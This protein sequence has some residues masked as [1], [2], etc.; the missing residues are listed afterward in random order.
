MLNKL[1]PHKVHPF[2]NINGKKGRRFHRP[3]P[4]ADVSKTPLKRIRPTQFVFLQVSGGVAVI[5]SLF[6]AELWRN[7]R[8]NEYE[9]RVKEKAILFWQVIFPAN[10]FRPFE[11]L[12]VLFSGMS[13]VF[14]EKWIYSFMNKEK[15]NLKKSCFRVNFLNKLRLGVPIENRFICCLNDFISPFC[16]SC[17]LLLISLN[18]FVPVLSESGEQMGNMAAAERK[19]VKTLSK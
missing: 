19:T 1:R 15:K 18:V 7:R 6:R 8:M 9:T 10:E 12:L 3:P 2:K 16:S 11:C 5:S 13:C 17:R 4:T 14:S